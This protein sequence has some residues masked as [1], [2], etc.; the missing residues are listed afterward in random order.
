MD[1]SKLTDGEISVMLAKLLKPKYD[2]EINPHHSGG[3]QLSWD[4]WGTKATSGFF[5]LRNAEDL[6]HSMKKHRICLAP[7]G[8][9]VWKASHESG[10]TA[11]HRNPLRAVAIVYLLLQDSANVQDNTA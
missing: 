2:S 6:F 5:P 1:Y 3:A 8:K 10:I 9:T 4:L 7:L 11:T